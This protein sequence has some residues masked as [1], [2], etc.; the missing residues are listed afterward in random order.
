MTTVYSD[1]ARL[2]SDLL[3]EELYARMDS[4]S[5]LVLRHALLPHLYPIEQL[6]YQQ[7]IELVRGMELAPSVHTP[8]YE[9]LFTRGVLDNIELIGPAITLDRVDVLIAL[10]MDYNWYSDNRAEHAIIYG[11][12]ECLKWM[13]KEFNFTI[14][15]SMLSTAFWTI[16]LDNKLVRWLIKHYKK[17]LRSSDR[18]MLYRDAAFSAN[19]Y[20]LDWLHL[21]GPIESEEIAKV[22]NEALHY[23]GLSVFL[24]LEERG[25]LGQIT[26]VDLKFNYSSI[27]VELLEW[28]RAKIWITT[29]STVK[30]CCNAYDEDNDGEIWR[31]ASQF[32]TAE[33]CI[34]YANKEGYGEAT[35]RR[36]VSYQNGE[37]R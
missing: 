15:V 13:K 37:S 5:R 28:V 27:S 3:R 34:D 9:Y 19:T 6:S 1:F 17:P 11:S 23:R 12:L 16:N 21:K 36:L 35:I 8:L 33:E 24:W 18:H 29:T 30:I 10:D 4:L 31:W 25:Y 7:C 14:S 32:V 26:A 20:A 22:V 2:P